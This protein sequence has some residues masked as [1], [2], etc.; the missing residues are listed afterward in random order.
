MTIGNT[1]KTRRILERTQA[2]ETK[3]R[4]KEETRELATLKRI[5]GM[6]TDI[7]RCIWGFVPSNVKDEVMNVHLRYMMRE[8]IEDKHNKKYKEPGLSCLLQDVPLHVIEKFIQTPMIETLYAEFFAYIRETIHEY[9]VK[10]N[11]KTVGIPTWIF[12][13]TIIELA[14]RVI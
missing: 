14:R 9:C 6:P 4:I 12:V 1:S 8:Q 5:R 11:E 3:K 13:H 10:F 2:K 7:L